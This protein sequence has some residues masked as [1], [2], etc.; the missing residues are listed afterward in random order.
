M[1]INK[2]NLIEYKPKKHSKEGDLN[3]KTKEKK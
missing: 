3:E 2:D 1:Q